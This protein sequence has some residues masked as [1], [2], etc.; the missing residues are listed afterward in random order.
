MLQKDSL[1]N[2]ILCVTNVTILAMLQPLQQIYLCNTTTEYT[3]RKCWR[4][5]LFLHKLTSTIFFCYFVQAL[6][7]CV[8]YTTNIDSLERDTTLL[9]L[10]YMD[11]YICNLTHKKKGNM[12]RGPIS[13]NHLM[14]RTIGRSGGVPTFVCRPSITKGDE[15]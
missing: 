5:I 2:V 14:H 10:F 11:I 15:G 8:M 12:F 4:M 3:Q 7:M 13:A 1:S 6:E 9:L